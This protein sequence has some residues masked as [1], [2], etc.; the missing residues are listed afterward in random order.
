M[1]PKFKIL[2][3]VH[4]CKEMPPEMKHFPSDFDAI[5]GE[6]TVGNAHFTWGIKRHF[7]YSLY[8]LENGKIVNSSAWY[9]EDQLTL[10]K[11]Q[12]KEKAG[13]LINNWICR[14]KHSDLEEW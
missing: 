5:I 8:E 2:D 7:D 4:V 10:L 12:D 14:R 6:I 3:F 11:N 9:N 1:K 13:D